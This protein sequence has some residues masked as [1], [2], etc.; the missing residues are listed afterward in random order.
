MLSS[1]S[2][3]SKIV[4]KDDEIDVGDAYVYLRA[5]NEDH[6]LLFVI[7]LENHPMGRLCSHLQIVI[8]SNVI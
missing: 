3:L 5:E 1:V 7:K 2:S 6:D 8:A 4:D